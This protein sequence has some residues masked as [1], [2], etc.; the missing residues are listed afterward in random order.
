MVGC[1]EPS[2]FRAPSRGVLGRGDSVSL[3]VSSKELVEISKLELV[4]VVLERELATSP[5][6]SGTICASPRSQLEELPLIPSKTLP[7]SQTM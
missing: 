6:P 5:V 3:I 2:L 4:A 1:F 7:S